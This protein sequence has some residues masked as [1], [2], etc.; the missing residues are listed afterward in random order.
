MKTQAMKSR[1]A[2]ALILISWYLMVPPL[3]GSSGVAT[4]APYTLWSP[5]ETSYSSEQDCLYAKQIMASVLGIST[6]LND[7]QSLAIQESRCISSNNP[8]FTSTNS[9][10][11]SSIN[12]Q[13]GSSVNSQ[14]GS[15]MNQQ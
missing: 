6:N 12:Q 15:P 1:H 5:I 11:G 3:I 2:V 4:Q 10:P 8:A 13:P 9:Q 14:S 7:Q